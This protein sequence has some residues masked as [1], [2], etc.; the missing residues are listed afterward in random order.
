MK[1]ID[2]LIAIVLLIFSAYFP[3]L[4]LVLIFFLFMCKPAETPPPPKNLNEE[5][6][7]AGWSALDIF[8]A[9]L[10]VGVLAVFVLGGGL[11]LAVMGR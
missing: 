6:A 4:F 5:I 10:A 11:A 7:Q 2:G 8:L 9:L 3:P 1:G